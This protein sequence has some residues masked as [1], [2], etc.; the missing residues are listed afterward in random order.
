[1][2]RVG[3][4]LAEELRR[5]SEEYGAGAR[6]GTVVKPGPEAMREGLFTL[7]KALGHIRPP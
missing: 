1:M 3:E 7:L 5:I 4:A 6:P 2:G